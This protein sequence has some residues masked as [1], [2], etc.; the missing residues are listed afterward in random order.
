MYAMLYQLER[1]LYERETDSTDRIPVATDQ[2]STAGDRPDASRVA[3]PTVQ[4]SPTP[5]RGVLA[6]QLHP[7]HEEPY[8][9]RAQGMGKGGAPPDRHPQALQTLDRPMARSVHRALTVNHADH[10]TQTGLTAQNSVL[11]RSVNAIK[12]Y[13]P[14]KSACITAPNNIH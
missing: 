8:G 10:D 5:R 7:S 14:W 6:D 2:A 1:R 13:N 3:H 4:G 11:S 12:K 9:I